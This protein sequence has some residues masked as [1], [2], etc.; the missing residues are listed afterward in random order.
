MYHECKILVSAVGALVT[1]NRFGISGVETFE[2]DIV[3]TAAWKADLS[4]RQ[5]DVII[6]VNGCELHFLSLP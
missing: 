5:K 4:L 3:H 2:G 6:V 1:P